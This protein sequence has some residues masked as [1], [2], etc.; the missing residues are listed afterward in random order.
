MISLSNGHVFEYMVASG[1]LAFDGRG[2][3]G[4]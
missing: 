3:F 1:A 2:F 4:H